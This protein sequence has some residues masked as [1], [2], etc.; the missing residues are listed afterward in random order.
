MGSVFGWAE[1]SEGGGDA[2]GVV[3]VDVVVQCGG[4]F[5]DGVEAVV[6][7]QFSFEL[8]E[9]VLDNGVVEAGGAA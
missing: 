8:A 5:L 9:E 1:A 6:V 3:P 2:G 4:E 7:E